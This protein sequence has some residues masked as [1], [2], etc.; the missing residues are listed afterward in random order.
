MDKASI[1]RFS[2]TVREKLLQETQRKAASYGILP[3]TIQDVDQ[4]FEDSIIIGGKVFNK[5]IKQQ[6]EQLVKEVRDKGYDQVIDEIT[7]TW[8]NRFV[9]LKF[10]E[11]N[12]Y[13]PVKVFSSDDPMKQEPDILTSSLK[14]DFLNIDRD[15]VIDMKSGGKDEELYKYLILKLCNY[16]NHIMPFLFEHIEDYTEL[17]FPGK[18]LHTDSILKDLNEIIKEDDWKEVEVIGWIYQDYI[19]PRKDKV[20]ADLK[21][22]IKI[23]KENIPAATQ[24]FTPKWIVKYLVENSVG[25]LWLES[26]PNKDLQSKFRY[27]IEQETRPPEKRISSP[28][29]ISVLD[30][31][32]G[33]GHILVYAFEVLYEIYRSQGY[34]ESEIAP[35]ILNKN[36]Y[37]LEIDDR[38][39]QLAGFA[40]MMKA[41]MYDKELFN[42]KISLSLCAIQETREECALNRGKYPELCRLWDFFIDAKNYGS[43]LK[44]DGFDFEKLGNEV[45]AL[46]KDGTLDFVSLGLKVEEIIKQAK[47]MSMKYDCVVTNPPYMSS[48]GM[49]AKLKQFVTKN[50]SYSKSDLFAV[51]IEKCLDFTQDNRFTS[52]ITMQ[53][54]MFLSS[55][56]KLRVNIL[57]KHDIDTMVH[58]GPRAFEQ[59]GGEVVSTTAFVMRR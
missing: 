27:F 24:L 23:S 6:R 25:R 38:A 2:D 3:D 20:F 46:K 55:F 39:A 12:R 56:E 16:L 47:L 52:M 28:E 13:L 45:D 35:L 43:I 53:S 9:A 54:W 30:P 14:L 31:A 48:S 26:N 7:Y 40:L 44:V 18:L 17:L 1:I 22:N 41:R 51:F 42:K 50:Y 10:M 34:L 8:F 5:K 57:D 4:E 59:I 29:E 58:L 11:V 15:I 19:N 33:S 36:L 37:G 21:K 49:N 32:K